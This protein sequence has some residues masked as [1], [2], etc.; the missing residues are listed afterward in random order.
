MASELGAARPSIDTFLR[1]PH[2]EVS[3]V[4]S[5]VSAGWDDV[6][7]LIVEGRLAEFYRHFSP[8]HVVA[9]LLI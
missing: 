3:V 4:A 9:F 8:L 5:T 1:I 7:A 6:Q 2:P